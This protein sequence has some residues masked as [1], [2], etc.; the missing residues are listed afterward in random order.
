MYAGFAK[1]HNIS[2][3]SVKK[4][5]TG[6]DASRHR[7]PVRECSMQK[8]PYLV[9]PAELSGT[10]PSKLRADFEVHRVA[11]HGGSRSITGLTHSRRG[12][13]SPREFTPGAAAAFS[14]GPMPLVGPHIILTPIT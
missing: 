7:A 2:C 13:C 12:G 3:V 8:L 4:P 6:R 1:D 5:R 11:T 9:A 14:D 10:G